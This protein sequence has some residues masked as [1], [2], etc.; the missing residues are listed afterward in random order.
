LIAKKLKKHI[1]I[2]YAQKKF[3]VEENSIMI[4]LNVVKELLKVQESSM[5][6]FFSTFVESTNKRIDDFIS[7]ITKDV[8]DFK[9]SLEHTQAQVDDIIKYATK[10]QIEGIENCLVSLRDKVDDL[11][12][13]S[14]RNNLCF[15]GIEESGRHETWDESE[16][17]IKDLIND[18]LELN[19]DEIQIE[20]AHRVGKPKGHKSRTIIAKFLNYK[21]RE[22]ILKSRRQL[23]GTS[24]TIREDYSDLVAEKRKN[25]VPQ[26]LE[27]RRNGKI[28]YLRH[29][30]L[31]V[32]ERTRPP[33]QQA[34]PVFS[35]PSFGQPFIRSPAP[36]GVAPWFQPT[37]ITSSQLVPGTVPPVQQE[38][39]NTSNNDA[40]G[41]DENT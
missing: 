23:K 11:E 15:E 35:Q 3:W 13:R 9:T 8:A 21:D 10:S 34:V 14:R 37:F 26:M 2:N 41:N 1:N 29:D 31:I 20:R 38:L 40:N 19:A 16:K 12:N 28:A 22:Q 4:N 25:L 6:A 32:H 33:F 5:K 24:I 36:V 7:S 18:K 27:A 39:A 17:I 30:K